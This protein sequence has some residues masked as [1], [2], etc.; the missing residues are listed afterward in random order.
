MSQLLETCQSSPYIIIYHTFSLKRLKRAEID[1]PD[2]KGLS[3]CGEPGMGIE[4]FGVYRDF[5]MCGFE[6]LLFDMIKTVN[7]IE[8]QKL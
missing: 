5:W 6:G 4:G 1:E 2:H 8:L 3:V 7:S